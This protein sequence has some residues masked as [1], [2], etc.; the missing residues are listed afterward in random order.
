MTLPTRI[1]VNAPNVIGE[2]IGGEVLIVNLETGAY[3]SSSGLG[4]A[5]WA[6]VAE[7]GDTAAIVDAVG[8]HYPG[9]GVREAV[10]AFLDQ[11]L[12]E[13]LVVEAGADSG[14][15]AATAPGALPGSFEA[16]VLRKYTDM[17]DL[18]LLDPIHEV[19]ET[20]WP[21]ALP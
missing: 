6:M 10:G 16:P 13:G 7:S 19:A 18:L 11:L 4:D 20:G 12:D 5:V 15:I 8:A 2:S 1:R 14:S 17:Q 9:D 3:F 21:A